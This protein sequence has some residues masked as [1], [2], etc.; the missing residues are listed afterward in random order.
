MACT[1]LRTFLYIMYALV[2]PWSSLHESG[3]SWF[4]R[5]YSLYIPMMVD[6]GTVNSSDI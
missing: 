2:S 4:R 3:I 6:N 1:A 5:V